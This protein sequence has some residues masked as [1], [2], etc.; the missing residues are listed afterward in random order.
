MPNVLNAGNGVKQLIWTRVK[1][2]DALLSV[3]DDFSRLVLQNNRLICYWL[4]GET[5]R[6]AR[7]AE[8]IE[9]ILAAPGFGNQDVFWT[10][11]FNAWA[12]FSEVGNN[13]RA[14]AFRA[15]AFAIDLAGCCY[16]S[17]WKVRFGLVS[18]PAAGF[19]FL[20]Q[21][22]YHPEYLS[23]WVIDLEGLSVLKAV[24]AR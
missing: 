12:F 23:H 17:Y 3:R 1:L 10:T 6:A 19:D 22:K 9:D 15:K 14:E 11:C 2:N 20:L 21:F 24:P 7:C 16:Q 13:E 18:G 4:S 5:D 8:V